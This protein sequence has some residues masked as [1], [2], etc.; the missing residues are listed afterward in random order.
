MALKVYYG[1][2]KQNKVKKKR[3]VC[4]L[5]SNS[6]DYRF[7]TSGR[8]YQDRFVDRQMHLAYTRMQ[9]EAEASEAK[10]SN[11][12][13]T[14]WRLLIDEPPFNGSIEAVLAENAKDDAK[15]VSEQ[16]RTAIA[17][18]LRRKFHEIYPS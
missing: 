2:E 7:D 10:K 8:S 6:P 14:A 11:R 13:F 12:D 16:E 18:A 5:F 9:T 4:V 1:I 17:D 15:N 3:A